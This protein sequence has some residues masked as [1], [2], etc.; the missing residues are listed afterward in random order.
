MDKKTENWV[1]RN[2]SLIKELEELSKDRAMATTISSYPAEW[3]SLTFAEM[4]DKFMECEKTPEDFDFYSDL[5]HWND[6]DIATQK[7]L[8]KGK[9]REEYTTVMEAYAVIRK[10]M[11]VLK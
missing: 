10:N 8:L 3:N 7:I 9:E 6:V 1:D 4:Y 11:E 2:F 5:D